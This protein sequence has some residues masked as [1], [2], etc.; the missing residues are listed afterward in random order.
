M[1]HICTSEVSA[2]SVMKKIFFV[3]L[4]YWV[5]LNVIQAK[6]I[7]L[8]SVA[9]GLSRSSKIT[10]QLKIEHDAWQPI[11]DQPINQSIY[12]IFVQISIHRNKLH[13]S[14]QKRRPSQNDIR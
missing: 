12:F 8:S 1:V 14:G 13:S 5:C 2:T 3:K 6:R 9:K 11:V 4:P 7:F 10:V